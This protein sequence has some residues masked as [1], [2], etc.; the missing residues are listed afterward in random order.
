MAAVGPVHDSFLL[1]FTQSGKFLMQLGKPNRSKGSNDLE[2]LR[3]PAKSLV[4]PKTN[5][6][7]VADG[8]G[9][10]RVIVF[11]ADTG[12]YKRHWGAYGNKPDD[13]ELPHTIRP[14]LHPS[15]SALLSTALLWRT[16]VCSMSVI[17]LMIACRY[18]RRTV[19]TSKKH[20]SR[21]TRWEMARPSM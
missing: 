1:K 7:Y 10:R 8:Y 11:D 16:T 9:N 2:N 13:K 17:A 12:K 19:P 4:D 3:L 20:S 14:I 5:E 6:L 15:S 18:S 21:R